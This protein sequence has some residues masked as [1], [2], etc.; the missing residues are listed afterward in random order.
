MPSRTRWILLA[1]VALAVLAGTFYFL[2]GIEETAMYGN[3]LRLTVKDPQKAEE[4]IRKLE[5]EKQLK[6]FSLH[7]ITPSLE[8]IFVSV[9][10]RQ[11]A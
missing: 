3:K 1:V 11:Q 7:E 8:D 9:M 10:S 5:K 6:V 2:A 4:A